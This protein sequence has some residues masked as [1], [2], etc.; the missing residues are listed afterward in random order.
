MDVLGTEPVRTLAVL[1]EASALIYGVTDREKE[2]GRNIVRVG[3]VVLGLVKLLHL[4]KKRFVCMRFA[5]RGRLKDYSAD[6]VRAS[7]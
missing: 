3:R 2:H 7:L 5:G 4:R 1:S 6:L